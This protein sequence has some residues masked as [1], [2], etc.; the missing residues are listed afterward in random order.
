MNS[1]ANWQHRF[2]KAL[3]EPG[4][5]DADLGQAQGLDVYRNNVR[6]SLV[7]ALAITFAHTRTLIGERFFAAAAGSYVAQQLPSDPRLYLY[8]YGFA[9]HLDG[10]PTLADYRYVSDICRLERARLD[11]SHAVD[12]PAFDANTLTNI[13]DTQSLRLAPH[14]ASR[15]I[16][17]RYDVLDLWQALE[18][19]ETAAP[20]GSGITNWL[21]VRRDRRIELTPV[22]PATSDLY[23]ALA[24][25]ACFGEAL[26]STHARHGQEATGNALGI[27]LSH[28]ALTK[29]DSSEPDSTKENLS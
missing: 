29:H 8:G 25:G 16:V 6:H 4:R 7:E 15:L 11:I 20:L 12:A 17:G 22:S 18:H 1:L 9:E 21:M 26:G 5:A 19:G 3:T 14:P 28:A 27:L 24:V 2:A 23:Q 13:T 10:L